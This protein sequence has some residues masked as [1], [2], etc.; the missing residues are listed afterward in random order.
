M[1]TLFLV[2][3]ASTAAS[4]QAR[5]L[6]GRRD[7]PLTLAGHEQA[8][9]LGRAIV[10]E[11][12][13]LPAE[14]LRLVS[15]PATRCR[16]TVEGMLPALDRTAAD[17]ELEPGLLE[18]DYGDWDGLTA[19]ECRKR[20]PS[21]RDAWEADPFTTACPSGESGSDVAA[22]AFPVLDAIDTWLAAGEARC[23][24][25]VAHNHV[26]RLRL[27]ALIGWPMAEYRDRIMQEAGSYSIVTVGGG[28]PV[29]RRI[30]AAPA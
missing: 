25:V 4:E 30:N 24:I 7:L 22:R 5:N 18:I 23:A 27:C 29:I 11:L 1:S 17:V 8:A 15:S 12:S 16:Q 20:D 6:G 19:E 14:E 28:L 21:L 2:R 3:H 13:E 10:H 9:S 26:N